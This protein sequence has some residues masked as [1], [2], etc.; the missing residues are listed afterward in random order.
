MACK[1]FK[2]NNIFYVKMSEKYLF[3]RRSHPCPWLVYLH[4]QK[5]S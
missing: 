3:S 5:F 1:I 2:Q 4:D